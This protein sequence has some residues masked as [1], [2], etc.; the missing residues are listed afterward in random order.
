MM[1]ALIDG[2]SARQGRNIVAA[3][4]VALLPTAS[5]A[6]T[7]AP[8][9]QVEWVYRIRYGYQDEWWK[10]FQKYQIAILDKE[11]SL[12]YV[13]GYIV[14]RPGLHTSEDSRWDFRIVI[15]YPNQA[16]ATHES[17]VER[18]LF[19]DRA[20]LHKEEQRR[21]ELTLNHWDLPIHEID[22]H[23]VTD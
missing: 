7:P 21:W 23:K 13:S 5:H 19:P 18:A 6:Q 15:T 3:L 10:I 17:E 2:M 9:Y 16:G 1:R 4:M 14:D 20:T 11:K 8:G 22:P 12:G